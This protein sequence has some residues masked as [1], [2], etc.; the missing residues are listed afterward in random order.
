MGLY[1]TLP[2]DV[3]KKT[4]NIELR[5]YN[6]FLLASTK[7][8]QNRYSDSGFSNV[9]NYI[10]GNNQTRQKISMTTPVVTYE[11]DDSLVTGFYVPSK[12]DTTT[13][14]IP[15]TDRV[16]IQERPQSYYLVIRFRGSWSKKNYDKQDQKLRVFLE[17]EG[18][19]MTS[20]RMIFRYQPP[21]V[22]GIFRRNEI[23]YQVLLPTQA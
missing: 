3:I 22:P 10:S 6:D 8:P 17:E 2:Y 23:A 11:Q 9:F 21:F 4:G 15:S 19:Q 5:Q 18:Y 16:F 7:T 1:E 20:S 12:F 13:V 14:P